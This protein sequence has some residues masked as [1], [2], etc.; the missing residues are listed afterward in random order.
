MKNENKQLH[1][2]YSEGK[3]SR[4]RKYFIEYFNSNPLWQNSTFIPSE[5]IHTR[6]DGIIKFNSNCINEN[7]SE[8]IM[9][10]IKC[11]EKPCMELKRDIWLP[12]YK[13]NWIVE[14]YQKTIV[15]HL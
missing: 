1:Y 14:N 8:N 5:D 11:R 15:I 9:V 7:L 3:E 4:G 6:F 10:E 12:Q 2:N 13:L